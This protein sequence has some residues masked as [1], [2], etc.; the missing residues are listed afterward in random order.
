MRKVA[1]LPGLRLVC[2]AVQTVLPMLRTSIYDVL[3]KPYNVS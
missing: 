2:A 3:M 1:G